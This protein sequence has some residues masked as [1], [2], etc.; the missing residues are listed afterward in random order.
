MGDYK[1]LIK[2]SAVSEIEE[3][4]KKDRLRVVKRIQNLSSNP[5][6]P[7]YEKLSGEEKYRVRQ[8]WYRIIY[9]VDESKQTVLVVR[10]GHRRDVYR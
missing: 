3:L 6:L 2:P 4:P 7:G 9:S 5:R 1:I 8:G 10:V